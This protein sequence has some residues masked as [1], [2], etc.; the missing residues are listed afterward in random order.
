MAVAPDFTTAP[1]FGNREL[2]LAVR[3][4]K[5]MARQLGGRSVAARGGDADDDWSQPKRH[6][7]T[8]TS[9]GG[10]DGVFVTGDQ[11][12]WLLAS[13][14]GPARL[15][16]SAQKGVFS[17]SSFGGDEHPNG[18]ALGTREVRTPQQS[19]IRLGLL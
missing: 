11:P 10:L 9:V 7:N 17:F 3:F 16:E 18:F 4:V 1:S 15:L 8:F 6:L 2:F 5:S 14:Q 13:D 12:L 19:N